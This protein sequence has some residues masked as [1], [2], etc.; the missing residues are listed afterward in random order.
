LDVVYVRSGMPIRYKGINMGMCVG[1]QPV[2]IA[3]EGSD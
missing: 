3:T 2:K 1:L